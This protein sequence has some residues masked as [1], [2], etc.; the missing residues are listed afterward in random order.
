MIILLLLLFLAYFLFVFVAVV[1][2][3]WN[4]LIDDDVVYSRYE[5]KLK[6]NIL[7]SNGSNL[8]LVPIL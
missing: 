7:Y 2:E 6:I 4:V 3:M 1:S 8:S 5:N